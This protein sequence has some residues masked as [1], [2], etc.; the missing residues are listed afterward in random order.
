MKY[1]VGVRCARNTEYM[2]M[3]VHVLAAEL[4]VENK[5]SDEPCLYVLD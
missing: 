4:S 3:Y 5:D 2:T 1:F